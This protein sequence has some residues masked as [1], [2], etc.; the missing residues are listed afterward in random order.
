MARRVPWNALI[1]A[2]LGTVAAVRALYRPHRTLTLEG[3]VRSCAAD[4]ACDPAMTIDAAGAAV[5][6]PMA[7]AV[8][9]AGPTWVVLKPDL[10][11]VLLSYAWAPEASAT[12][13]IPSG[14]HVAAGQT[15]AIGGLFRFSV[16]QLARTSGGTAVGAPYEP[17]A[18]L[19]VRGLKVSAKA[20]DQALWCEG[21]RSLTVPQGVAKCNIELPA[22]SP[23]S[24]LP[25]T[26]SL[27]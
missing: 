21:G 9:S 3:Y 26:V 7:A 23:L 11:D 24:L 16:R 1:A 15:I 20:R 27:R 4:S 12:Q 25:V 19:A 14:T 18:W 22:P 5:L 2:T 17:A 6:A 10:D 8:V 13:L